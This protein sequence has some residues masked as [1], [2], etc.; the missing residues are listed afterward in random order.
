MRLGLSLQQLD[1]PQEKELT[2]PTPSVCNGRKW[3][4]IM[5]QM[6]KGGKHF[7]RES[8][9][10]NREERIILTNFDKE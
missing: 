2:S 7:E 4:K 5:S 1:L 6:W 9:E 10:W 3:K 8:P